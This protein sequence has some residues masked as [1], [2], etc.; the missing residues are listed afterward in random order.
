MLRIGTC[1]YSYKDWIGPFYPDGIRDSLMLEYYSSE[2]DFVEVNSSF[3][4][5]PRQQLFESIARRT[6]ESFTT[7]VKLFQGFTHMEGAD[8]KLAEAFTY[9][10]KPLVEAGKLICLLAQFP[11][12]FRFTDENIDRLKRLR[13]WFGDLELNVEFRNQSWIKSDV[14]EFLK[15]ENLGFVC[16]D[17]PAIKGLVKKVLVTTSNVAYL[18][19]HG[20]NASKWYGSEGMERYDYLYDE[21]ELM[22]WVPGIKELE[23]ESKMTVIAFNNHPKGKA[24]ENSRLLLKLLQAG[25]K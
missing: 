13:D 6:P 19:M 4:H 2:F 16:V 10:I 5:M 21:A 7:A 22:E 20:R 15:K 3:Y 1:G 8:E 14:I 9:S 25:K 24:V 23:G 11:Y 17:E 18:R 12:S